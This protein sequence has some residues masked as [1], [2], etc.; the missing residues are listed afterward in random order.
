LF[1]FEYIVT[2]PQALIP[3]ESK[4]GVIAGKKHIS[5][6]EKFFRGD[7]FFLLFLIVDK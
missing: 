1:R 5:K 7:P 6:G 4:N 2:P 3:T